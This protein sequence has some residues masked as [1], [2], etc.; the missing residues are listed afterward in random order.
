MA[1]DTGWFGIPKPTEEER[2]AALAHRGPSWRAWFLTSFSMVY[3]GLALL[4]VDV[5]VASSWVQA[6]LDLGALA[7][8][9]IALLYAEYLLYQYLWHR[10]E[11]DVSRSSVR[12]G[13]GLAGR[14]RALGWRFWIHPFPR[15]RW[16]HHFPEGRRGGPAGAADGPTPEEFL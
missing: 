12:T 11:H 4:T 2:A 7:A 9:M 15:G 14:R 3:L 1:P 13:P 10:P 16:T 5:I 6:R 8:L